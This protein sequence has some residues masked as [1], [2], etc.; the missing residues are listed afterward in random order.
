[1]P[2]TITAANP[3]YATQG[4][5]KTGQILAPSEQSNLEQAFV[6]RAVLSLSSGGSGAS[7]GTINFI[8][9]TQAIFA[10]GTSQAYPNQGTSATVAPAAVHV[11]PIAATGPNAASNLAGLT[12]NPGG[13]VTTTG[14]P[15]TMS[16]TSGSTFAAPAAITSW[17]I[18]SNV[19]T[20]ASGTLGS[21][22]TTGCQFTVSGLTTGT[23]LNGVVFTAL[24]GGSTSSTTAN[25]THANV[26]TVT[27][28][29]TITPLADTI[30][31]QFEAYRS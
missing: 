5:T 24:T 26:G 6:G 25:F 23:Y 27:E 17:S 20:F 16:T 7:T 14:F 31:V 13:A 28:A 9:G 8:D 4:P 11:Y 10:S 22:I 21:A 12:I 18:T 2:M 30:T 15:F 29:G 3:T 19:V 1:M